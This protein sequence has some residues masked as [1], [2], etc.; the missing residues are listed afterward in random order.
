MSEPALIVVMGVSGSGKSTLAA[1][2]AT[3][4]GCDLLEGDGLHPEANVATMAR[5]VPLTDADR[6]PWLEAIGRWLD[7]RRAAGHGAVVTCSALRRRYR[8]TLSNGRP[9]LRFCHID[10]SAE[11]LAP[12]LESRRG[13]FMPARLLSSQLGT[14]EPLEPDEPGVT[15]NADGTP[16][17]VLER[18]LAALDVG[19]AG[20]S[21]G[22]PAL[23]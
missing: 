23:P 6:L 7:V 18:A 22:D 2:L 11:V 5:G 14:L 4:L 15:I 16:D 12:R 10:V 20:H 13:H 17:E 21:A 19:G 8:D 9:E 3:A 1:G